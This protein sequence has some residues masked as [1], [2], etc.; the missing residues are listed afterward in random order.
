MEHLYDAILMHIHVKIK[1]DNTELTDIAEEFIV[2]TSCQNHNFKLFHHY[3]IPFNF[4][5]ELRFIN[6]FTHFRYIKNNLL[7]IKLE[8]ALVCATQHLLYK[9]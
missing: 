5:Y 4:R 6:C 1:A 2:S 3:N 8:L 9:E 7:N